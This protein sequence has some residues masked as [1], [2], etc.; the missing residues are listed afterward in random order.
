MIT[1]VLVEHPWLSPVALVLLG[2][3][4]PL[5]GR[6]LASRPRLA[7]WAL[8]ASLVPV[9]LLTLVPVDRTLFMRC[10][11][12]W[13]L[14]TFGRVE[15]A[16]NVVLF[17]VPALLAV[18]VTR[19]PLVALAALSGLSVVI[20]AVQALVPALGRSCSTDDWLSDTIGAVIGVALGRLALGRLSLLGGRYLATEVVKSEPQT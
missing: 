7:R 20:E 14:P 15:L 8:A 10:E 19:R 12:A 11:T 9:A 17:V 16:A 4:G 2:V 13:S 6:R 3:L 5:L 18:V 1:T